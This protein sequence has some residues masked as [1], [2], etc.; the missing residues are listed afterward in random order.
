MENPREQNPG[1]M[2][3]LYSGL[4]LFL[5]LMYNLCT[6]LSMYCIIYILYYLADG[7][8]EAAAAEQAEKTRGQNPGL[9][10]NLYSG[11]SLFLA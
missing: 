1:L 2:F 4:S 10:F 9:M 6:V 8:H 11:L 3:N 7:S 5:S